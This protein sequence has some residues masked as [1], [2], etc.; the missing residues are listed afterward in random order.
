MHGKGIILAM[1]DKVSQA[2]MLSYRIN[3]KKGSYEKNINYFNINSHDD[4]I[5]KY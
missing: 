5:Y 3:F 2:V 1:A 4:F